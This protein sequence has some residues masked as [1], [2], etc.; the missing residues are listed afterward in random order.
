MFTT[1]SFAM[2]AL[3]LTDSKSLKVLSKVILGAAFACIA[4]AIVIADGLDAHIEAKAVTILSLYLF[5]VLL[6][7]IRRTLE[8]E[9]VCKECNY[10]M[11]W[12]KC[13]GFRTILCPLVEHNFLQPEELQKVE[14]A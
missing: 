3:G 5:L 12:S 7:A 9:K 10:Q 11:R 4:W 1:I 2:S 13:P 6:M 8:I 14:D